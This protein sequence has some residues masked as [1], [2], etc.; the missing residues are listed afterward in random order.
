MSYE[1]NRERRYERKI[2]YVEYRKNGEKLFCAGFVKIERMDNLCNI[3]VTINRT[4]RQGEWVREVVFRC[5]QSKVCPGKLFFKEGKAEGKWKNVELPYDKLLQI[6]ISLDK[7]RCLQCIWRQET[8]ANSDALTRTAQES[9]DNVITVKGSHP[10]MQDVPN[11]DSYVET[12]TVLQPEFAAAENE[13][14]PSAAVT[15]GKIRT[16][17]GTDTVME[18]KAQPV[19]AAAEN[20]TWP[21]EAMTVEETKTQSAVVVAEAENGI[22]QAEKSKACIYTATE[23]PELMAEAGQLKRAEQLEREEQPKR[24]EQ[25]ERMEQPERSDRTESPRKRPRPIP[26]LY[27]D[28]WQQLADLYSHKFPFQDERDYLCI[29]PADF[30]VLQKQYHKLV[31][32]SFLLHGFYNYEH[33][34][35]AR[36]IKNGKERYYIGVP[37]NF[38]EKERQAAIL[39]GFE[40]FECKKEPVSPG[41]FGYFMI[42]VEI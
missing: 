41:E 26:R 18:V 21:D 25:P 6:E 37:G 17:S 19:A 33:L 35:L 34:I 28:K 27:E 29:T 12:V 4:E 7:E 22:Q 23:K 8:E 39:F 36:M 11:L 1:G 14:R 42:S 31:S 32:N 3:Q 2:R 38:Y 24:A 15:D 40:S 5:G 13:T 16:Q 30:V 9:D 20:E 10:I